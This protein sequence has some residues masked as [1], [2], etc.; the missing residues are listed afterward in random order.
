VWVQTWRARA[1]ASFDSRSTSRQT[2][3]AFLTRLAK[4]FDQNALLPSTFKSLAKAQKEESAD[5]LK[6][7]LMRAALVDLGLGDSHEL[8]RLQDLNIAVDSSPEHKAQREKAL[9]RLGFD[10][11]SLL[12]DIKQKASVVSAANPLNVVLIEDVKES[13]QTIK[14][15]DLPLAI[16]QTL[17]FEALKVARPLPSENDATED[18]KEK[19]KAYLKLCHRLLEENKK[20][21]PSGKVLVHEES[22]DV[23]MK[24]RAKDLTLLSDPEFLHKAAGDTPAAIEAEWGKKVDLL[25]DKTDSFAQEGADKILSKR[26]LLDLRY[27]MVAEYND[28]HNTSQVYPLTPEEALELKQGVEAKSKKVKENSRSMIK[29]PCKLMW[30]GLEQMC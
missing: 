4:E 25:R 17:Q 26:Q 28:T 1:I 16:R 29:K 10:P 7:R 23:L 5:T 11:L 21:N 22:I 18:K 20:A 12:T 24:Q 14:N 6:L 9:E 27:R 19:L 8:T 15:S 3:D 2:V 13:L 30:L